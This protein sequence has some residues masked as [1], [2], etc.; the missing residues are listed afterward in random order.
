[1]FLAPTVLENAVYYITDNSKKKF[2]TKAQAEKTGDITGVELRFYCPWCDKPNAVAY[3]TP[4]PDGLQTTCSHC[5]NVETL[6]NTVPDNTRQHTAVEFEDVAQTLAT[7]R[8]VRVVG[9]KY[10]NKERSNVHS[11]YRRS[12]LVHS[13]FRPALLGMLAIGL[14]FGSISLGVLYGGPM[15]PILSSILLVLSLCVIGLAEEVLNS[16]NRWF[17]NRSM[18]L[19]SNNISPTDIVKYESYFNRGTEIRKRTADSPVYIPPQIDE[20]ESDETDWDMSLN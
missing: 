11:L 8:S 5:G 16:L 7:K 1:M 18:T 6:F 4:V 10:S 17:L 19:T 3:S 13:V 12:R 15:G 2:S 9:Q 14:F 20:T